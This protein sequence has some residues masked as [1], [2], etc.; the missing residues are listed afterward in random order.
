MAYQIR[1]Y[2]PLKYGATL[3]GFGQVSPTAITAAEVVT[4]L[5]SRGYTEAV[6]A[7]V[8]VTPTYTRSQFIAA[9]VDYSLTNYGLP[10]RCS[11]AGC[12]LSTERWRAVVD[13]AVTM[14]NWYMANPSQMTVKATV[15]PSASPTYGLYGFGAAEMTSAEKWQIILNSVSAAA[16][17]ASKAIAAKAARD[18]IEAMG[19]K[20]TA[21]D[22]AYIASILKAQGM[23]PSDTAKV[24]A[25]LSPTPSWLVPVLIGMG[26]LIVLPMLRK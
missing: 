12:A 22:V 3:F 5:N 13:Y 2:N 10:L 26:I 18:Q 9:G 8:I 20:V 1:E 6:A 19:S 4:E 11:G 25:S 24:T 16:D 14:A 23:A 17:V 15:S 7:P 21:E